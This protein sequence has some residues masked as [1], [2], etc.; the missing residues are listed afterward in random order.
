VAFINLRQPELFALYWVL[1][2]TMYHPVMSGQDIINFCGWRISMDR[3]H[4]THSFP[5]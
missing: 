1:R 2:S 4:C 5:P 3:Y